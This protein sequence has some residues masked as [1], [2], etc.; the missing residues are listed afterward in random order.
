MS[1]RQTGRSTIDFDCGKDAYIRVLEEATVTN[2][3]EM[4]LLI[5]QLQNRLTLVK[6]EEEQE[7]HKLVNELQLSADDLSGT[8]INPYF[9]QLQ[10][11]R[12]EQGDRQREAVVCEGKA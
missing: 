9:D 8:I 2:G 1:R 6:K 3:Q 10:R 11:L 12:R 7:F 4:Q 5:E